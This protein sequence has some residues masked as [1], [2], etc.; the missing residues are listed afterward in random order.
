MRIA[1]IINSV[2]RDLKSF[3]RQYGSCIHPLLNESK[4]FYTEYAG[5]SVKL[6]FDHSRHFEILVAVGGDGTLHEVINGIMK[7]KIESLSVPPAVALLP[8]GS[9]NDFARQRKLSAS[10]DDLLQ[11]I[12]SGSI[13]NIDVGRIERND[14]NEDQYFINIADAGFGAEVVRRLINF[15][16]FYGRFP[17]GLKFMWAMTRAFLSYRK[18]H[19]KITMD[20]SDW[21][22]P[23][24]S[25]IVA[26]SSSFGSGLK[27]APDADISDGMFEIVILGN[28][29]FID[30]LLNLL[31]VKK[32][33]KIQHNDV[34][35]LKSV[36]G[37]FE[38]ITPI[39]LEADGEV[40]GSTPVKMVCLPSALRLYFPRL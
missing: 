26:N 37:G 25:V 39:L 21:S 4:C 9:A 35:Y 23:I 3:R 7:A 28:V 30:Y 20:Q 16:G 13:Q 10:L 38:G 29:G 5:H 6:S 33:R 1:F 27:I 8:Y 11:L 22:G 34:H 32:G 36:K 2:I 17:P 12:D 18:Q 24:L 14:K 15:H 31:R 19:V 40:A